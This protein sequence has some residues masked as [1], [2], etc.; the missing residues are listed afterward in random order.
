MLSRSILAL[1]A[2][3]AALAAGPALAQFQAGPPTLTA[4]ELRGGTYWMQG[5]AA[6]TGF[7]IGDNGVVVIDVQ[8]SVDAGRAQIAQIA[9]IT[10]K[11]V[12]TVIL[13]HG[14]P[15]HVGGLPAYAA[16]TTIIA[17][18]NIR[19]QIIAAAHD[20][21]AAS[22]FVAAYSVI[23]ATRLP[24]RT[25]AASESMTIDGVAITLIHVAPAHSTGDIMVFL[26]KQ[27]VIF[28]G[29]LLTAA[30]ATYPII[31]VG[32]SS[33]GWIQSIRTLLALKADTFV[34]GHGGLMTKREVQALL[35][36]VVQR[37]E[38]IK[39]LVYQGKSLAEVNA[40][41]PEAK[42]GRMFLSFNETTYF[43]LT[44][45]YPVAR[46]SWY[47]LAPTDD[48]RRSGEDHPVP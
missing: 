14:D 22:P 4:H 7:V 10:P 11:P 3:I 5:D 43:E 32:G 17:H 20:N 8:R 1:A 2:V 34:A 41:L 45:G 26:P 12:R 6:N 28:V 19:A 31:H 33:E 37:R 44:R 30:E 46:P 38:A 40:A 29:D 25:I 23:A 21:P 24:N 48:R 9:K 35:D 47:S 16:D 39:S 13:T 18:E 42:V 36:T 15:D 27:R